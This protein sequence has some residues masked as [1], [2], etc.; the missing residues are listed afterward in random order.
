[1]VEASFFTYE[2]S[3]NVLRNLAVRIAKESKSNG[4]L[5]LW[6]ISL[7]ELQIRTLALKKRTNAIAPPKR[8]LRR[9]CRAPNAKGHYLVWLSVFFFPVPF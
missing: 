4:G 2:F 1:M 9:P 3:M 5:G 8:R 7:F 6:L